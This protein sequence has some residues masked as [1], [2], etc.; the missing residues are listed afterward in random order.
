MP[1][2]GVRMGPGS[3]TANILP[4][5]GSISYPDDGSGGTYTVLPSSNLPELVDHS[6]LQTD[7]M[8]SYSEYISKPGG[9]SGALQECSRLP[10]GSLEF[11]QDPVDPQPITVE[12]MQHVSICQVL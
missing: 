4:E 10:W 11:P 7:S 1:V 5:F 8:P 6:R 12:A 9:S 2:W 3:I